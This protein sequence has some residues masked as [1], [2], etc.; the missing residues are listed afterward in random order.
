MKDQGMNHAGL[1][2]IK[3]VVN[4]STES[5]NVLKIMVSRQVPANSD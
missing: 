4:Q 3:G 5:M 1:P 2:E